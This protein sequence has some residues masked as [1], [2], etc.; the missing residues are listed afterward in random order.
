MP[1]NKNN[2]N[3]DKYETSDKLY[4]CIKVRK[5]TYQKALQKIWAVLKKH[6]ES[7]RERGGYIYRNDFKDNK[8]GD[9]LRSF[10]TKAKTHITEVPGLL[11]KNLFN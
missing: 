4:D 6:P 5:T 1:G 2:L 3:F 11:S 7:F 10:F 8:S 9:C